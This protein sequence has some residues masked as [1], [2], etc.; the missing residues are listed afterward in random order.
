MEFSKKERQ[1]VR[2]EKLRKES[3]EAHHEHEAE[4][5]L[6][7][8]IS[9]DSNSAKSRKWIIAG[10]IGLILVIGISA[11]SYMSIATP[12]RFDSF[13]KCLKEKGVVMYGNDFCSYTQKQLSWFEKSRKELNYVRCADNKQLCDSKSVRTTPTWEINGA[14]YPEV[15]TFERLSTLSGCAIFDK[16][17][18]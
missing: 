17:G 10:V 18:Q 3:L 8:Q 5:V 4:K 15:Q 7:E 6:H 13:A 1:K 9:Q 14:M 11:F 16:K 12:G 2:L